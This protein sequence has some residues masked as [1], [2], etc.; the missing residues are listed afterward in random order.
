VA[1]PLPSLGPS[2]PPIT[3]PH[4]D[5]PLGKTIC[6]PWLP[7]P[8]PFLSPSVLHFSQNPTEIKKNLTV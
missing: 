1:A 6:P 2:L 3:L 4:A 7:L 8:S 5:P